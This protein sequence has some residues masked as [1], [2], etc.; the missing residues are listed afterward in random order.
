MWKDVGHGW[1][2]LFQRSLD[3]RGEQIQVFL[4]CV[5]MFLS[6]R[7]NLDTTVSGSASRRLL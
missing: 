6:E 7:A 1:L 5:D 3:I 4:S 2:R